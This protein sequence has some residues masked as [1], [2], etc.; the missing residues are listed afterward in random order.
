MNS[1][2][3]A[4]QFQIDQFYQ[5]CFV[6]PIWKYDLIKI[7]KFTCNIFQYCEY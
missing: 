5:K 7:Y 3:D 2:L 1:V 6:I 4:Y